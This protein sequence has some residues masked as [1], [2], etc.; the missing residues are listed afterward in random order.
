M[1]NKRIKDKIEDIDRLSK[2]LDSDARKKIELEDDVEVR[3]GK[4]F[5][6]KK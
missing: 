5:I 3:S 2:E 1:L 4:L 6:I